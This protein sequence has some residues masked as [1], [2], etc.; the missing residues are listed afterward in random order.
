MPIRSFASASSPGEA[1]KLL[2]SSPQPSRFIAGGTDLLSMP[3]APASVVDVR[4]PLRYARR[5]GD[6]FVVGAGATVTMVAEWEELARADGGFLR[7]CAHDFATWQIRNLATVGG[8]LAS[9]VPS[10]D[11]AVPFLVLGAR[12]VALGKSG[13]RDI[14]IES[15]FVGPHESA[16]G[17]D[18]LVEVRFRAPAPEAGLAWEKI[19]R[20]DGDIAIV[21]AAALVR[22]ESGRCADVRLA[23]GAVAPTPIR[24][25]AAEEFLRGKEPSEENLRRAGDLAAEASRPI[26]DQR[27]SAEYRRAMCAV[28]ARR[29]LARAAQGRGK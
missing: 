3:A 20:V 24:V 1:V 28:L 26:S 11:F 5:E 22:I 23:L 16:L 19:G 8:N 14:P 18:L 27:A 10:A 25:P 29:A 12:I 13:R 7:S 4:R 17:R 15:F 2:E 6:E 21:N 9:A